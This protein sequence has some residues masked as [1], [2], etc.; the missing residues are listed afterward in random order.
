MTSPN[1]DTNYKE[2]CVTIL[3][4]FGVE[5][6][7]CKQLYS[8][9]LYEAQKHKQGASAEYVHEIL[10]KFTNEDINSIRECACVNSVDSEAELLIISRFI[11]LVT[12]R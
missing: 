7:I 12:A 11:E 8:E 6:Y 5:I 9:L 2:I 10:S 1:T 3:I 4:S